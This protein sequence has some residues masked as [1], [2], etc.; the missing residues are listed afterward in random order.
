VILISVDT[1][2]A[3]I[4]GGA[5]AHSRTAA[6]AGVTDRAGPTDLIA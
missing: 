5:F 4:S 1:A 6:H 2:E 3:G